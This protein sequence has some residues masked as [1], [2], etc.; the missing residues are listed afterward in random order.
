MWTLILLSIITTLII[1]IIV[2]CYYNTQQPHNRN[3]SHKT[4]NSGTNVM[5]YSC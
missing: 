2:T 5:D 3:R 1:V 4:P